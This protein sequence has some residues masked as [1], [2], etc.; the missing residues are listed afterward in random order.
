MLKP[1]S[2]VLT[3]TMNV[4]VYMKTRHSTEPTSEQGV[5]SIWP[6]YNYYGVRPENRPCI[7]VCVEVCHSGSGPAAHLPPTPLVLHTYRVF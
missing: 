2:T 5:M 1:A 4:K 7:G 6:V 3:Y